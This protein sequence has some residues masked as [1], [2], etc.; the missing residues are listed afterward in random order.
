MQTQT[1]AGLRSSLF[2]ELDSLRHDKT[3]YKRARAVAS[4]AREILASARL[5]IDAKRLALEFDLACASESLPTI[6][7][8]GGERDLPDLRERGQQELPESQTAAA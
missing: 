4:L 2:S 8:T 5:E 3:S 1:T 6:Q 7:L